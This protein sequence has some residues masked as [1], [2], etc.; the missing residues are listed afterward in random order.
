M[1][2][3]AF[4]KVLQL[5]TPREDERGPVPTDFPELPW[6][7]DPYVL[8][9]ATQLFHSYF[10]RYVFLRHT[11]AIRQMKK[12]GI[13]FR[14]YQDTMSWQIEHTPIYSF[15]DL[16]LEDRKEALA[17]CFFS[18]GKVDTKTIRKTLASL[19]GNTL[20]I[21]QAQAILSLMLAMVD[22]RSQT[23][24]LWDDPLPASVGVI[25]Q[26]FLASPG[27]WKPGN[28]NDLRLISV[29]GNQFYTK[30]ADELDTGMTTPSQ[31][32][33][34]EV[35][36]TA[37]VKA[38][39]LG[40]GP[41]MAYHVI[42]YDGNHFSLVQR[43]RGSIIED[44][45]EAAKLVT[46]QNAQ[47]AVLVEYL[48]SLCDRHFKNVLVDSQ[49][50]RLREIDFAGAFKAETPDGDHCFLGYEDWGT[51]GIVTMSHARAIWEAHQGVQFAGEQNPIFSRVVLEESVV[52]EYAV[53][54]ALLRFQRTSAGAV[55]ATRFGILQKALHL[56]PGDIPLK[57]LENCRKMF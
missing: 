26:K 27:Y 43:L 8:T 57:D 15:F 30:T 12:A 14:L 25:M 18:L 11:Y 46:V 44:P 29:E 17:W 50:K 22:L 41:K 56:Y 10:L 38:F 40:M 39:G 6:G 53:A 35:A 45:S 52:K 37:A 54:Q 20:L 4:T 9:V 48:L 55:I 3:E 21:R 51:D 34:D 19:S 47:R 49:G 2:Q 1:I 36:G 28:M 32:Q 33:A 7:I 5:F 24:D 16:S 31:D 23:V 42:G 13:D